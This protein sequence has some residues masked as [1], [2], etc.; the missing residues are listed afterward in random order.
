MDFGD[1]SVNLLLF[2][3]LC[4]GVD[5]QPL[6]KQQTDGVV[7]LDSSFILVLELEENGHEF[8]D[9]VQPIDNWF[10]R[11]TLNHCVGEDS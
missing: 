10:M 7:S 5:L 2:L 1:E 4:V 8:S 11:F 3:I 9:E 6:E